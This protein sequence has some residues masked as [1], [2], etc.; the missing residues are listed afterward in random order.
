MKPLDFVDRLATL[1]RTE[2]V[3]ATSVR[4]AVLARV[5]RGPP[6]PAWSLTPLWAFAA[7][8]S[9]ER[10]A[11]EALLTIGT[12]RPGSGGYGSSSALYHHHCR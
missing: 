1:A 8:N 9:L 6:K 11:Q 12:A 4:G 2:P 3:P 10:I 5:L 7:Y